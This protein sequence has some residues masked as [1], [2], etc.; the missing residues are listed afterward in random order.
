MTSNLLRIFG[1]LVLIVL[2]F[3]VI[4]K[5][6]TANQ[7]AKKAAEAFMT[8]FANH[9]LVT[10]KSLLDPRVSTLTYAGD[11]ITGIDFQEQHVFTGAFSQTPAV[12]YSYN[13]IIS[14]QIPRNASA[15]V[16][17]DNDKQI[18][19]ATVPL[20]M[21]VEGKPA[22]GGNIYLKKVE[23]S[24]KVFYIAQPPKETER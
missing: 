21:N 24:W 15:K 22:S 13:E 14:R 23:G 4:N 12:K 1:I 3:L 20:E 19:L 16:T 7:P 10:V 9:N 18:E 11:R 8:A 2:I 17:Q 6:S 5:F